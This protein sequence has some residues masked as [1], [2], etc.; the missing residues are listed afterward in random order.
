MIISATPSKFKNSDISDFSG[1]DI[2]RE[3]LNGEKGFLFIHGKTGVGKSHLAYAIKN[4]SDKIK[5]PCNFVCTSDLFMQIKRSF[6]DK[7]LSEWAIIKKMA[8]D[9]DEHF[10]IRFTI[11]DDVGAQKVNEYSADIWYQIID[12]RYRFDYK[13][14]FTSN[15]SLSEISKLFG[16]RISSRLG[17]GVVFE[18]SGKDRRIE[19]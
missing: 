7:E 13:T 18:L 4:K 5:V 10:P 9:F 12:R 19:R 6:S 3:W 15:Y 1:I 2:V 17:S 8:P 16:D 11:F 14:I